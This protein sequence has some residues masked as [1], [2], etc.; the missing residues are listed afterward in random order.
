MKSLFADLPCPRRHR[1]RA[2]TLTEIVIASAIMLPIAISVMG[3]LIY[4]ARIEK[5]NRA[6]NAISY[7]VANLHRQM[8]N[9]TAAGDNIILDDQ[10]GQWVQFVYREDTDEGEILFKTG[11][12]S[13]N[14]ADSNPDTILDNSIVLFPDLET[15][16]E[17]SRIVI[18][19][20][21]PLYDASGNPLPIFSRPAVAGVNALLVQ[22]RVGDPSPEQSLATG[23]GFTSMVFRAAFAPRI[24][25]TQ[26]EEEP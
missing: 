6:I 15:D 23:P 9:I 26:Q 8:R 14:D 21:S 5:R 7:G 25:M 20:V 16:D 22:F 2:F 12:L 18:W 1:R 13:Y 4:A 19:N 3:A 17:T 11:R 10:N 24:V